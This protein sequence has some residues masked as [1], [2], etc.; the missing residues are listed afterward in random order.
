MEPAGAGETSLT[1]S[2]LLFTI[3]PW[4]SSSHLARCV[5]HQLRSCQT[6]DA[7]LWTH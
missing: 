3:V 6:R 1:S 4:P 7:G 5:L 2:R